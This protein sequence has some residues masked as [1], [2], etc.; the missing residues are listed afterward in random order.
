MNQ[1]ELNALQAQ[2]KRNRTQ[3]YL[4]LALMLAGVL[5]T[6]YLFHELDHKKQ[7]IDDQNQ[8]LKSQKED[9]KAKNLKLEELNNQLY[10][11]DSLQGEASA[12]DQEKRQKQ[13]LIKQI[14]DLVNKTNSSIDISNLSNLSVAQLE[15]KVKSLNAAAANFDKERLTAIKSLFSSNEGNRKKAR[16]TLLK[17]YSTDQSVIPNFLEESQGKIN[18]DNKATYYQF[19]YLLTQLDRDVLTKNKAGLLSYFEM[20]EKAGLNGSST[21]RQ[22]ALV[23]AKMR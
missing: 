2:L 15:G 12:V 8:L 11:L 6:A 19:I 3:S 18:L 4:F 7:L 1:S 22:I 9:I 5:T 23:K 10:L 17:K 13:S 16:R 21:K 14:F 20:G